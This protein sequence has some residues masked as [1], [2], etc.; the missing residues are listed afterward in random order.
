MT[1]AYDSELQASGMG[2]PEVQARRQ[3]HPI[4]AGAGEF[5]GSAV[6][7]AGAVMI[8]G[9]A[10][11]L[12][13]GALNVAGEGADL[14][15]RQDPQLS[16]EH[17]AHIAL[18]ELIA[19]GVGYALP[20]AVTATGK[21]VADKAKQ[22][23]VR[24]GIMPEIVDEL[25]QSGFFAKSRAA[26]AEHAAKGIAQTEGRIGQVAELL[27]SV[28]PEGVPAETR[29]ALLSRVQRAIEEHP[30]SEDLGRLKQTESVLMKGKLAPSQLL[31][32]EKLLDKPT[33]SAVKRD[34]QETVDH[35]MRESGVHAPAVRAL[36]GHVQG[37]QTLA[38]QAEDVAG[39][40]LAGVAAKT[41]GKM[42][43]GAA[44]G[45]VAKMVP[46]GKAALGFIEGQMGLKGAAKAAGPA[47]N[48]AGQVGYN[49][50]NLDKAALV[51]ELGRRYGVRASNVVAAAGAAPI[52]P[53]TDGLVSLLTGWRANPTQAARQAAEVV[54]SM[55]IPQ[56]NKDR[57][58]ALLDLM[59]RNATSKL[60]G[61]LQSPNP[62]DS[63]G[64]RAL[65]QKEER[66]L[67]NYFKGLLS[68]DTA[69]NAPQIDAVE[70]VRQNYPGFHDTYMGALGTALGPNASVNSPVRRLGQ[71]HG[72]DRSRMSTSLMIQQIYKNAT[73][74][75]APPTGGKNRPQAPE[76]DRGGSARTASEGVQSRQAAGE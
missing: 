59:R 7:Q 70:A 69:M 18:R 46:G 17:L 71:L 13:N 1:N 31:E 58:N 29:S 63:P 28:N 67:Q 51:Q 39:G 57:V 72:F 61:R 26:V 16:H 42:A 65:T 48:V 8:A 41:A 56:A 76:R 6:R 43:L 30:F 60:P 54:D 37:L 12:L 21:F 9:P 3:Q 73:A 20:S 74:P 62:F 35:L 44:V 10:G 27:D 23:A 49:L 2:G 66:K 19:A 50:S 14:A 22:V 45:P 36:Q 47:L 55:P 38:A 25:M 53:A 32:A 34:F 4:A 24:K 15:Y 64:T 68:P 33:L 52:V 5:I 11:L 75:S 40:D